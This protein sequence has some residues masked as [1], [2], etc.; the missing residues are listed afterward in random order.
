MLLGT[1][2]ILF[3]PA[4]PEE[5]KKQKKNEIYEN[6]IMKWAVCEQCD[7]ATLQQQQNHF[8][9]QT[10]NI[11]RLSSLLKQSFHSID[12]FLCIIWHSTVTSGHVYKLIII[13]IYIKI[14]T[15]KIV[16]VLAFFV[17]HF[18]NC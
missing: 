3:Q 9:H 12:I 16:A 17:V 11:Q 7:P 4:R 5:K 8:T 2:V 15:L 6:V 13:A 18:A 1:F 10:R 14:K